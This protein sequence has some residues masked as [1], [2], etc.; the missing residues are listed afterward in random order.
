MF[1]LVDIS[2]LN[3]WEAYEETG[4]GER[5]VGKEGSILDRLIP[6]D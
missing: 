3:V 4:M 6:R 2:N 1:A 5:N